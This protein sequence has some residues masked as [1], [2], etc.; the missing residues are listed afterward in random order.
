M[1]SLSTPGIRGER[2]DASGGGIASLRTDVAAFVGIARRGPLHVA[3]PVESPRQF[4]AWF[5]RSQEQGHLALCARAFFENGGRRLWAVRV[6]SEAA[7]S[8]FAVV[9]D[10]AGSAWRLEASS[11]GAWGNQLAVRLS[12]RRRARRRGSVDPLRAEILHVDG[13]A[14]FD[15]WTLVE[16]LGEAGRERALVRAIDPAR[17]RLVLDRALATLPRGAAVRVESIAYGLEVFEAHRLVAQL[18]ELAVEPRHT[19]YAPALLVQPWETIDRARPD[20]ED[21][22]IPV[23]QRAAEWFRVARG[24]GSPPLPPPPVLVRELR[25][26]AARAAL[27]PLRSVS[28]GADGPGASLVSGAVVPLAGGAD[29]LAGLS[30]TDFVGTDASLSGS[31][32]ALSAARRGIAALELVDEVSLVAVPDVHARPAARARRAPPARCVPEPCLPE[33]PAPALPAVLADEELMRPFGPD[34]VALVQAALVAHCE[35]RRDRVALLDPA[36]EACAPRAG[37][38]FE[39]REWRSRFDSRF[40]AAYAPWV[41]VVDPERARGPARDAL[42]RAIPPSGHVAGQCAALDLRSGVHVAPANAP[43]AWIQGATLAVDDEL[44]GLLNSLGVNVLRS[45]PGR[46]LRVLGARTVSSDPDWRFLNVRRLVSMI[47]KA[48]EVSLQWAAFEPGDWRT[49]AKLDLVVRSFLLELWSRGALVGSSPDEAFWVRCDGSNNL[50]AA[51][52][53]GRVLIEVGIA[54]TVPF[55]FIVLRIGRDANGFALSEY[56]QPHGAG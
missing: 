23:R 53:A 14:G 6:A 37:A 2:A 20:E 12:E 11:P 19:R 45:T 48:L 17:G 35:R 42:T 51:R 32:A 5:G 15:A 8:A 38:A 43:L 21:E 54:P 25:D 49:R 27:E 50:A 26:A 7:S 44:H 31:A 3:V 36:P 24:L 10:A 47:E 29:G 34:E 4:E 28:S 1:R 40:A 46:G 22:R 52:D 9:R 16:A 55:E 33:P 18:D 30:V 56:E 13:T 39:L 41:Q